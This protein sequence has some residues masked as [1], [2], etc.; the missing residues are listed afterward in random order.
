MQRSEAAIAPHRILALKPGKQ[1]R[2]F[3]VDSMA[4]NHSGDASDQG[5]LLSFDAL[6]WRQLTFLL[7]W[8]SKPELHYAVDATFAQEHFRELGSQDVQHAVIRCLLEEYKED[9]R[10]A[11][12]TLVGPDIALKKQVLQAYKEHGLVDFTLQDGASYVAVEVLPA[13]RCFFRVGIQLYKFAYALTPAQPLKMAESCITDRTTIWEMLH[14]IWVKG[15]Q[16]ICRR[17]PK[18]NESP[19]PPYMRNDKASWNCCLLQGSSSISRD[20]LMLLLTA[21]GPIPQLESASSYITMLGKPGKKS[22]ASKR[23]RRTPLPLLPDGENKLQT[24]EDIRPQRRKCARAGS[25][26][27]RVSVLVS[28]SGSEQDD[29]E[30]TGSDSE[31]RDEKEGDDPEEESGA[32]SE[33]SKASGNSS[34]DSATMTAPPVEE[35]AAM[36]APPAKELAPKHEIAATIVPELV[37]SKASRARI[38]GTG[39]TT[40]EGWHLSRVF[41]RGTRVHVGWEIRCN[42]TAHQAGSGCRKRSNFHFEKKKVGAKNI[43]TFLNQSSKQL[44]HSE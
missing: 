18:G 35:S 31:E 32:H 26:L 14:T 44:S 13:G 27:S 30:P 28:G 19:I 12:I 41:K 8:D 6:S 42:H 11:R 4:I 20:Y 5:L 24:A 17:K 43:K 36:T 40:A 23:A 7:K 33:E 15:F 21:P 9:E 38:Y 34:N 25:R 16:F 3:I 29:E 39:H 37:D 2:G 1:D 22:R 10:S